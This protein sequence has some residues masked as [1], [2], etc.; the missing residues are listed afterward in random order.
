M[1]KYETLIGDKTN[2]YIDK[3]TKLFQTRVSQ[4]LDIN[5]PNDKW[6]LVA[7][8]YAKKRKLKE[9]QARSFA[10]ELTL[11]I[12]GELY[13]TDCSLY[14]REDWID[15][16]IT[17]KFKEISAEYGADTPLMWNKIIEYMVQFYK[18]RLSWKYERVSKELKFRITRNEREMFDL[19]PRDKPKQKFTHLLDNF[20]YSINNIDYQRIGDVDNVWGVNLTTSEYELFMKIVGESKTDKFLNMLYYWFVN[21]GAGNRTSTD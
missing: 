10:S 14:Y 21:G 3:K 19:V 6:V 13:D 8:L 15:S 16:H 4:K 2:E 12:T 9:Y 20:D 17:R 5:N 11:L 18:T 7:Y 1:I